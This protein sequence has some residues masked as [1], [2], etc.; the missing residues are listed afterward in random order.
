MGHEG[1]RQTHLSIRGRR[2]R[3]T[4]S[5]SIKGAAYIGRN[6]VVL[7]LVVTASAWASL[8]FLHEWLSKRPLVLALH[9]K[10]NATVARNQSED[11]VQTSWAALTAKESPSREKDRNPAGEIGGKRGERGGAGG[12]ERWW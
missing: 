3:L 10:L 5:G 2:L 7:G 8:P 11:S 1:V 9:G 4:S 12:R 6:A